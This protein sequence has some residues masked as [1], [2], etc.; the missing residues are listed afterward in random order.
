MPPEEE[1]SVVSVTDWLTD[2]LETCQRGNLRG[3]SGADIDNEEPNDYATFQF[4]RNDTGEVDTIFLLATTDDRGEPVL[5]ATRDRHELE[6]LSPDH[7]EL[8]ERI[9]EGGG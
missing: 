3:I 5:R 7:R 2:F 6:E 1:D 8:R 4:Q 9:D